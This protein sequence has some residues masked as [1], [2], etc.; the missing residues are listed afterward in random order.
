MATVITVADAFR[1]LNLDYSVDDQVEV[2]VYIDAVN[3]WISTVVSDTSPAHVKLAALFLIDHLWQS[4]RGPTGTPLSDESID[5][6][7]V[8]Y[9]I[10]NRVLELLGPTLAAATPRGSFPSATGWPDPVE[11]PG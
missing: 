10:P 4:Q 6:A 9:A 2:Q 5:V 3:S 7:G 1:Q 11:W 8:G